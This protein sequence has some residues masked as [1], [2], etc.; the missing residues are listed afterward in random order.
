MIT[1]SNSFNTVDM[2]RYFAILPAEGGIYSNFQ[3]VGSG[4]GYGSDTNSDFLSVEQLR[5]LIKEYVDPGFK[6]E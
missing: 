5:N 3:R 2:D 1:A 4:K 6:V